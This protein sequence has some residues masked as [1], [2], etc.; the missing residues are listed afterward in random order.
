[1]KI[2]A[3]ECR[4]FQVT[5]ILGK[6]QDELLEKLKIAEEKLKK[7]EVTT[8]ETLKQMDDLRAESQSKELDVQSKAKSRI[9]DLQGELAVLQVSQGSH[10]QRE[11][12]LAEVECVTVDLASSLNLLFY[13]VGIASLVAIYKLPCT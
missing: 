4:F 13:F 6:E 12:L 7:C 2:A 8:H 9:K 11:K 5:D 10:L 1:L 3:S